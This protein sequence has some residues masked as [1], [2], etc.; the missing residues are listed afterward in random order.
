VAGIV[1]LLSKDFL[2]LVL[3]GFVIAVPIAW[4]AM[5]RWLED[6]A[7]RIN[8]GPGVFVLAGLSAM[9]VA[10]ATVSFQSIKAA[11]M[12]PVDSLRNE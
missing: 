2:K 5:D 3:I 9:L 10:L 7:Y 8:I 6:F 12:N 11:L 4:Y 1:S